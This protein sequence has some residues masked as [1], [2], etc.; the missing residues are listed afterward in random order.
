MSPLHGVIPIVPTPF[1]ADGALDESGLQRVAEWLVEQGVHGLGTLGLASEAPKLSEEERDRVLRAV[2]RG[3][4]GRVPVVAGVYHEATCVAVRQS[5]AAV[6]GGADALMLFP[7]ALGKVGTRQLIDHLSGIARSVGVPVIIQDTPQVRGAALTLTEYSQLLE[8]APNVRYA[9]IEAVPAGQ[10]MQAVLESLGDRI[11]ILAGW[12]G[13]EFM[14]AL[15]RG[16]C[17]CM[18]GADVAP[19]LVAVYAAFRDGQPEQAQALFNRIQ[20]LL[21]FSALSLDR[22]ITVAKTVLAQHGLIAC[23][24]PRPPFTPF[25]PVER[26]E[27]ERL[28][29]GSGVY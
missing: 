28:L 10:A 11:D 1:H 27:M 12:G 20:P 17:G 25:D 8:A 15:R 2:V 24:D 3:A 21:A 13:L 26:Q 22:F 7:P 5:A 23:A 6:A 19:A 9:K 4:R 16:A 29:W 18:P 14:D